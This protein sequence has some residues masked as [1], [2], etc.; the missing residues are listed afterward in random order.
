MRK[1]VIV[2]C[3]I[4]D[5]IIHWISLIHYLRFSSFFR[6]SRFTLLHN[7]RG[8]IQCKPRRQ[9][10]KAMQSQTSHPKSNMRNLKNLQAH[11]TYLRTCAQFCLCSGSVVSGEPKI[12]R[13]RPECHKLL[14]HAAPCCACFDKSLLHFLC[15]W[16]GRRSHIDNTLQCAARTKTRR[17][18]FEF[19]PRT[20]RLSLDFFLFFPMYCCRYPWDCRLF[21]LDLVLYVLFRWRY[22]PASILAWTLTPKGCVKGGTLLC[23]IP[24]SYLTPWDTS[25]SAGASLSHLRFLVASMKGRMSWPGETCI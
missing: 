1:S 3:N 11:L 12:E 23:I 19:E 20:T 15:S 16:C 17:T 8:N 5:I 21:F 18:C 7:G 25:K 14:R 22:S 9:S 4:I 24:Q 10:S 2:R 13:R 6:F